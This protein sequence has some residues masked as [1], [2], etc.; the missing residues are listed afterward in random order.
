MITT[1]KLLSES[2]T[3]TVT[4]EL[5]KESRMLKVDNVTALVATQGIQNIPESSLQYANDNALML[6]KSLRGAL[7]AVCYSSALLSAFTTVGLSLTRKTTKVTKRECEWLR[8]LN[9][10]VFTIL[11]YGFEHKQASGERHF[12]K[13]LKGMYKVNSNLQKGSTQGIHGHSPK[14]EES[15]PKVSMDVH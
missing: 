3:S 5:K 2:S 11:V 6:A 10:N 12:I 8:R 4:D 1:G 13:Q 9:V 7:L 14:F 15:T